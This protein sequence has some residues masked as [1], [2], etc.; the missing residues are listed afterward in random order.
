MYV[1]GSSD[2][3]V[4]DQQ[5]TVSLLACECVLAACIIGIHLSCADSVAS[6]SVDLEANLFAQASAYYRFYYIYYILSQII[7]GIIRSA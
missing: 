6:V 3:G 2:C 4:N 7:I 1:S 5:L